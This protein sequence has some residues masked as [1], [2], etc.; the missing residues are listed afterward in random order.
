MELSRAM[1]LWVWVGGG[2][3]FG[4]G[5]G[6]GM[7]GGPGARGRRALTH[8]LHGARSC[9]GGACEDFHTGAVSR[10]K[11]GNRYLSQTALPPRAARWSRT[12]Q[13]HPSSL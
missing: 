10:R 9:R 3:W 8:L 11:A 12:I 2:G 4:G 7:S 13:K 1:L 5:G 6:G